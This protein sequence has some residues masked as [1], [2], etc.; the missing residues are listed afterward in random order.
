LKVADRM[1]ALM[2]ARGYHPETFG[3]PKNVIENIYRKEGDRKVVEMPGVGYEEFVESAYEIYR[4][5]Q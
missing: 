2:K 4:K 1:S 5:F 3:D